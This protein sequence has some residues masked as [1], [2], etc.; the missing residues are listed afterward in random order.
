MPNPKKNEDRASYIHRAMTEMMGVEGMKKR[1]ALGK[2]YG[3]WG[4]YM[5]GGKKKKALGASLR[6]MT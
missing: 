1:Q 6:L 3:L 2:A 4:A 5:G